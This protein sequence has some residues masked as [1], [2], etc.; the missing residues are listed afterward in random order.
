MGF[1]DLQKQK[2]IQLEMAMLVEC[3]KKFLNE[4]LLGNLYDDERREAE[5]ILKSMQDMEANIGKKGRL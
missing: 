4:L 5:E 2:E 1:D 3:C